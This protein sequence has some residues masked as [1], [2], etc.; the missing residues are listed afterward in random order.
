VP[1]NILLADDSVPAQNMGKKILIDAG[2]DVQTVGN[3][4]EALRKIAEAAPDIAILDIF[5]P[6]YTGLEICERLRGSAAT[7]SLPVILTVG[8][9][10][11]FRPEDGE[12]VRSN[13]VVVKPF[14]GAELVSAV[15]S[16][17]G[18]P[19]AKAAVASASAN[20]VT[21]PRQNLAANTSQ[22]QVVDLAASATEQSAKPSLDGEPHE[23]FFNGGQEAV[24]DEEL[25]GSYVVEQHSP[26]DDLVGSESLAFNP[27]A[28]HIAFSASAFDDLPPTASHSGAV[29]SAFSAG[30]FVLEPAPAP[31]S[32]ATEIAVEQESPLTPAA[33]EAGR[34]PVESGPKTV[35]PRISGIAESGA[36]ELEVIILEA[37]PANVSATDIASP[38]SVDEEAEPEDFEELL[39][40]VE[41]A[42]AENLSIASAESN[43][44]EPD[45]DLLPS[46]ASLSDY[47]SD[48]VEPDS[49]FELSTGQNEDFGHAEINS[50]LAK[51]ESPETTASRIPERD[52][53][54]EDSLETEWA[55]NEC[56]EEAAET[57][58]ADSIGLCTDLHPGSIDLLSSVP[59]EAAVAAPEPTESEP[60]EFTCEVALFEEPQAGPKVEHTESELVLPEPA[61]A[62]VETEPEP[63]LDLRELQQPEA[64]Q[65]E[66]ETPVESISSS[67]ELFDEEKINK[68]VDRVFDRF[69]KLLVKAIMRE[70]ARED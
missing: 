38:S 32:S 60:Q 67:P 27:D 42:P 4:L 14:A 11:P 46:L 24:K 52:P 39:S 31:Y 12:R 58:V 26:T 18:A 17:I 47:H 2:Y 51:E 61:A 65:S 64:A 50:N 15:R 34:F 23:P 53:L 48:D 59:L 30:E 44:A 1:L 7:A 55:A 5:M 36:A 56:V 29:E 6:G 41:P 70:L 40:L 54:L 13:A 19:N 16:L 57:G 37:P 25:F 3:G 9:L 28:K 8:K 10:E 45:I 49:E 63:E 62:H 20:T 66:P 33:A 21:S 35:Q 69:K 22:P 43:S 68:A